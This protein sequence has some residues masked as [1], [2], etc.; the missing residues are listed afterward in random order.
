MRRL[1]ILSFTAFLIAANVSLQAAAQ[2]SRYPV[3]FGVY[4]GIGASIAAQSLGST[5]G[6][7][8][9]AG[10]F[11]DWTRHPFRPG[12]DA[13]FVHE[14]YSLP[15]FDGCCSSGGNAGQRLIGPRLAYKVRVFEP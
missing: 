11:A 8:A 14:S 15:G 7:E 1:P 3:S 4:G 5:R 2:R 12:V 6:L 10:A 9:Q 13:R